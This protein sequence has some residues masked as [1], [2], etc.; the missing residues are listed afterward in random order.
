[1]GIIS[2]VQKQVA[3]ST[4]THHGYHHLFFLEGQGELVSFISKLSHSFALVALILLVLS[5]TPVT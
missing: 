2:H 1:M 4:S 3:E 5:W